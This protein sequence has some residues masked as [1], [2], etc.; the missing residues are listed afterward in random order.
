MEGFKPAEN[1]NSVEAEKTVETR[2]EKIRV[3][4]KNVFDVF[5]NKLS[6]VLERLGEN[7][8]FRDLERTV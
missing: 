7:P 2:I 4:E 1:I 5:Q 6:E 8:Y 3:A